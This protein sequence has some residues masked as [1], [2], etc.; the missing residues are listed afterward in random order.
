MCLGDFV[1]DVDWNNSNIAME[2]SFS[3]ETARRA[4]GC[5]PVGYTIRLVNNVDYRHSNPILDGQERV[6]IANQARRRREK[7]AASSLCVNYKSNPGS[8]TT[9]RLKEGK[10]KK[11]RENMIKRAK[12][13]KQIKNWEKKSLP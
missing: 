7:R 9:V 12:R 3:I 6:L 1:G 10:G 2:K 11:K 13:D 5:V 8:L 4:M